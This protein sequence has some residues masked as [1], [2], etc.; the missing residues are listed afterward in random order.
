MPILLTIGTI[1]VVIIFILFAAILDVVI[2]FKKG[3]GKTQAPS[4]SARWSNVAMFNDG[5]RFMDALKRDMEGAQHHI[6]LAFF[7]FRY[8][9]I[10]KEMIEALIKH[11]NRGVEVRLL[12][13]AIGSKGF[14]KK[15]RKKLEAAQ[16][17]FAYTAKLYFPFTI[18][19]LNRRN[20]HKTVV[21][22]GKTGYFG[23]FN[24][25]DEY[26]GKKTDMGDW[27]DYHLKIE[28]GGVKDLQD[29]FLS[30]WNKANKTQ[31]TG[32]VYYPKLERGHYEMKIIP[33]AGVGLESLFIDHLS[34]AQKHVFIG[35]AYYIPTKGLQKALLELLKRNVDVTILL[36]L[37]KDH[38]FVRPVSYHYLGPLLK[39]GAK[40]YHFYQGFYH[41]KVFIVDDV[42]CYMGT[43][44]FDQR[45]FLWNDEMSGFIYD[46]KL[47]SEIEKMTKE[48]IR[49]SMTFTYDDLKK[50]PLIEKV[51]TQLSLPLAPLL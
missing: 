22:D 31:I 19:A 5:H 43:A 45:S 34:R 47:I 11:A 28:G 23:G 2:A 21:I 30:H 18:Y 7:I 24:I 8:D 6:H 29:Q 50:R 41:A 48:D 4:P 35:T 39:H 26:L 25:G 27:R 12:L 15:A 17:Q 10:G 9:Q 37:R 20:H 49:R 44:N 32:D 46:K 42:S 14:P 16:I 1:L 33:T 40:V 3:I 38:P 13:D 36:P 51:K